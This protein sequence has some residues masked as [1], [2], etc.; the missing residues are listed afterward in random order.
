MK[1]Q[2]SKLHR[3]S[4]AMDMKHLL[5]VSCCSRQFLLSTA[6]EEYCAMPVGL[7]IHPNVKL[8]S[9]VVEVLH[10]WRRTHHGHSL[11]GAVRE[12]RVL[13]LVHVELTLHIALIHCAICGCTPCAIDFSRGFWYGTLSCSITFKGAK[14]LSASTSAVER[15]PMPIS[16]SC[17]KLF[18]I[19]CMCELNV[20]EV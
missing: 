19:T 2:V 4:L 12:N 8:G 15:H 10:A 13:Y 6:A 1:P 16:R 20:N 7:K 3:K 17:L 5:H 14:L 18:N 11:Q 9:L